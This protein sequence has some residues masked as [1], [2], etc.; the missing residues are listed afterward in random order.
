MHCIFQSWNAF[1]FWGFCK[2]E[3]H[4]FPLMLPSTRRLRLQCWFPFLWEFTLLELFLMLEKCL[5][6]GILLY[7]IFLLWWAGWKEYCM[8]MF[9]RGFIPVVFEGKEWPEWLLLK[10]FLP[11][12]ALELITAKCSTTFVFVD[13]FK[14]TT[15]WAL[16]VA[17][18]KSDVYMSVHFQH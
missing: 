3:D 12:K 18:T 14:L 13:R 9:F 2:L 4:N 6:Y 10:A 15:V 11:C 17:S 16:T 1:D 7:K 5:Y 8:F